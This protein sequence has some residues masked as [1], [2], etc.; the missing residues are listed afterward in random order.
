MQDEPARAVRLRA[1][2]QRNL[3][4]RP[5][6]R[7]GRNAVVV[8]GEQADGVVHAERGEIA[9][10]RGVAGT[11]RIAEGFCREDGGVFERRQHPR[12]PLGIGQNVV[13]IDECD[14]FAARGVY[15]GGFPGLARLERVRAHGLHAEP[16]R[17][18]DR[19]VRRTAVRD[20]D[21]VIGER[22]RADGREAVAQRLGGVEGGDDE[23]YSHGL[24][25]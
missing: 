6:A 15:P 24:S 8:A 21:F 3:Q 23:R 22:L 18:A 20:D 14:E 12:E 4:T 1:G 17:D 10:E 9:G 16:A 7:D 13:R 2:F 5:L 25:F 11:R 19:V